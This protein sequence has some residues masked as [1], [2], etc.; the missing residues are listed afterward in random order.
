MIGF[1]GSGRILSGLESD[2]EYLVNV[3][4]ESGNEVVKKQKINPI[5]DIIHVWKNE[6]ARDLSQ[7]LMASMPNRIKVLQH[8]SQSQTSKEQQCDC[9]CTRPF[10]CWRQLTEGYLL[11]A[12]VH[13]ASRAAT[14]GLKSPLDDSRHGRVANLRSLCVCREHLGMYS[15]I[16]LKKSCEYRSR[17]AGSAIVA[18]ARAV[19][20]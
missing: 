11:A 17:R 9:L 4:K 20:W 7:K 1:A 6:I 19:A 12:V 18:S 15:E 10:Q 5:K 14:A 16:I 13:A 2:R 3:Q 8:W